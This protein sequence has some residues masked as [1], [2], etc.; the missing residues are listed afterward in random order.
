MVNQDKIRI[1]FSQGHGEQL[2]LG[3]LKR[4]KHQEDE[5]STED[6]P[7]IPTSEDSSDT[8]EDS[9]ET[10]DHNTN[11]QDFSVMLL[12]MSSSEKLDLDEMLE[13]FDHPQNIEGDFSSLY[14]KL[15]ASGYEIGTTKE[16]LSEEELKDVQILVIGAPIYE[17]DDSNDFSREEIEAITRFVDNGNGLL[18]IAN[19]KT[20]ANLPPNLNQLAQIADVEFQRYHNYPISSLQLFYPHFI[21][22]NIEKISIKQKKQQKNKIASLSLGHHAY[23]LASTKVTKEPVIACSAIGNRRV[24]VIGTLN[25]IGNT[26]LAEN[27]NNETLILNIFQWLAN[28]N[29]IEIERLDIP[30]RVKWGQKEAVVLELRNNRADTRLQI[31]CVLESDV[32]ASISIPHR[33]SRSLRPNKT[34]LMQWMVSPQ[35]L[36]NQLLRLA[37]E[38]SDH[39]TL[40]FDNL[41]KMVGLAVGH[42]D[43][44]IKD[45]KGELNKKFEKNEKI[46]VEGAFHW[47]DSANVPPYQLE[48][49]LDEGLILQ[50][51]EADQQIKRWYIQAK[52]VGLHYINLALKESSQSTSVLVEISPSIQSQIAE[53][54]AAYVCPLQAE[55]IQRLK[56]IDERFSDPRL[57]EQSFSIVQPE[58]FIEELYHPNK[59]TLLTKALFAAKR[60]QWYNTELLNIILT[61]IHPAYDPKKGTFILYN[62]NLATHLI[63][64]HPEYKRD[65]EHQLLGSE[66]SSNIQIKQNIAA[67]LLHEKFGHAFF[68]TH[69]RLGQQLAL[70]RRYGLLNDS[71]DTDDLPYREVAKLIR[72]SAIIVNEGL[73]T[74]VELTFLN[75]LDHEVR[76]AIQLRRILLLEQATDLYEREFD[77][78]YFSTFEPRYDSPYREGF[79]YLEFIGSYF[80]LRCAIEL[81]LLATEIELGITEDAQRAIHFQ[82]NSYE[83]KKRLLDYENNDW[84]SHLRLRRITD[85][86]SKDRKKAKQ[87]IQNQNCPDNC[88]KSGCPLKYFITNIQ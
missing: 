17:S 59:A 67:N 49:E 72:D 19:A 83:M 47:A 44:K 48:L 3:D 62:P 31:E 82:Y 4:K 1:L 64:L 45:K 70:L 84:R 75:H 35:R 2:S 46:I 41:P 18:L 26:L 10:S 55:I 71:N 50:K 14:Q 42:F 12:D 29:P 57:T 87:I 74:W 25:C 21:T 61:Y 88:R 23:Q 68:Y 28:R 9:S 39:S 69:T 53:I 5:S 13:S 8:S 43:L 7:E 58:K 15:R 33:K 77:S 40:Y 65:L 37:I 54:Y 86:L 79:E 20:M 34:T 66:E 38:I 56:V 30:E 32:D 76:L 81:F 27:Q 11:N 63:K 78:E 22:S 24:V 85:T 80:N 60:E 73:A 6:Q 16:E 51:S 52:S 36:G